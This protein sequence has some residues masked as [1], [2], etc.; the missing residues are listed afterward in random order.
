MGKLDEHSGGNILP[1]DQK[2][3]SRCSRQN[4][5]NAHRFGYTQ[6]LLAD[7]VGHARAQYHIDQF[8]RR[9]LQIPRF[10]D[11]GFSIGLQTLNFHR[12][13][14]WIMQHLVRQLLLL[15]LAQA[16]ADVIQIITIYLQYLVQPERVCV[17]KV[18][19]RACIPTLLR[20]HQKP[21]DIIAF[22]R[23]CHD[24]PLLI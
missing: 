21:V 5:I 15:L 10:P 4:T 24:V 23:L 22:I 6:N 20:P 12:L 1:F 2:T 11:P 18:T 19:Q 8:R 13:S 7:W 9:G 14:H 17:L 16:T 3:L